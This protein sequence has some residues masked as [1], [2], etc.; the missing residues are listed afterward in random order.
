MYDNLVAYLNGGGSFAYLGGNGL[1]EAGTYD[2]PRREMVFREGVEGGPRVPALFTS[3]AT[4][5]S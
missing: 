5:A 3:A 1:F 2:A 4:A